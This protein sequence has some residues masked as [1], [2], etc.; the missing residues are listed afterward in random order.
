MI[1]L[2]ALGQCVFEVG[3]HRVTPGSDVLFALLLVLACR[4]GQAIPRVELI[5]L[6][7]PESDGRSLGGLKPSKVQR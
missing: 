3:A 2:R 4:D 5:E 6:L 7:W 1:R